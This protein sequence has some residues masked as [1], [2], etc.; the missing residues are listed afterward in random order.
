MKL[1]LHRVPG[2]LL[3]A[4]ALALCL[5]APACSGCQKSKLSPETYGRAA[6]NSINGFDAMEAMLEGPNR[7]IM[8]SYYV[9]KRVQREADL[10]VFL[11]SDYQYDASE[12]L[13][14]LEAWLMRMSEEAVAEERRKIEQGDEAGPEQDPVEGGGAPT[15]AEGAKPDEEEPAPIEDQVIDPQNVRRTAPLAQWRL[16]LQEPLEGEEVSGGAPEESAAEDSAESSDEVAEESDRYRTILYFLRDTDASAAYWEMLTRQMEG[17]SPHEEFCREEFEQQVRYRRPMFAREKAPFSA[18]SLV[19]PEGRLNRRLIHDAAIFSAAPS[20]YPVRHAPGVAQPM[21]SN[22]EIFARPLLSTA[23]GYDLIRELYLPGARL[24]LVYNT[25]PFLNHS[26][27]RKEYRTLARELIDYSLRTVEDSMDG[28]LQIAIVSRSLTPA[29]RAAAQESLFLR[30]PTVFPINLIFAQFVFLL[31]LFLLS[32]W[33]HERRPIAEISA[34]S[35]EFLEHIRALGKRLSRSKNRAAALEALV[36]YRRKSGA[37]DITPLI[38]RIFA[39]S[40]TP[41][42]ADGSSQKTQN[43]RKEY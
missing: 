3:R 4:G 11:E 36:A 10:I 35:R 39:S 32:R 40:G 43:E 25:E 9:T 24:I 1:P 42:S 27:V 37:E 23:D 38:N 31:A 41:R 6:P 8:R 29:Q 18:L 15:E 17:V 19:D 22:V 28:E 34:G 13:L 12:P 2:R 14:D 20:G 30:A 16:A 33:P 5:A 26:L 7:E 21:F